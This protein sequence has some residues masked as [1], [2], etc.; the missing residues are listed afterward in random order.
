MFVVRPND[1]LSYDTDNWSG[2]VNEIAKI[3]RGQISAL[4]KELSK[5]SDQL[6][7]TLNDFARRDNI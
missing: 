6:Q 1:N 5:R 4:E 2:E 3:T 7:Q